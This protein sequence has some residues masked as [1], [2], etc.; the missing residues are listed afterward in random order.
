MWTRLSVTSSVRSGNITKFVLQCN[1]SVTAA[2]TSFV[3]I[4]QEQQTG[5]P[6][7]PGAGGGA[8]GVYGGKDPNDDG[9]ISCCSGCVVL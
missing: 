3:P 5:R 4:A 2:N 7:L 9:S 6:V 1:H 8:P